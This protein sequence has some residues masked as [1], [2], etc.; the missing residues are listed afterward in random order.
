MD[1][2]N[3]HRSWPDLSATA[4]RGGCPYCLLEFALG[5]ADD[6]LRAVSEVEDSPKHLG[7]YTILETLGKGGMGVVY[8]AQH[9]G[10]GRV[11]ALKVLN[12][13]CAGRAEFPLRFQR[14]GQLLAALDHPNIVGVYDLGCEAGVFYL[15]MELVPG[16]TL[17]QCL[18]NG[19]LP[20][21]RAVA[22]FGQLCDA[23]QYA[24]ERGIIH[25]DVKPENILVDDK[26]HVKIGDFGIA[27]LTSSDSAVP[28]ALTASDAVIGTRCY[29]APEQ[30][31]R[32]KT[33]DH[34]ADLYAL[35]AVFYEMLTGELPLGVFAPPSR[36]AAV[37]PRLDAVLLK[38]LDKAPE[39]RYRSA[40]EFKEHVLQ[41]GMPAAPRSRRLP[42]WLRGAALLLALAFGV[43]AW[44]LLPPPGTGKEDARQ[45][46]VPASTPAQKEKLGVR[47]LS[48][49]KGRVWRVAFADDGRTLATASEDRTVKLWDAVHGRETA[50]WEAFPRGEFGYLSL[51]FSPDGKMLATAGGENVVRLWNVADR[52]PGQVL[53][54]HG[55]E[56]TGLAF[57]PDGTLLASASHDRSIR[58]WDVN[59]G[60][61]KRILDGFPDPVLSLAFSPDGKLLTAGAMSGAVKLYNPE[62]GEAVANCGHAKR[63]WSL[64]FSA[65]GRRLAT[66]SHESTIKIWDMT[67]RP[68]HCIVA[69]GGSEVWSV[70]FAPDA[71]LLASGSH[72]GS[73][74]LWDA[75]TGKIRAKWT[76]HS[77][78]VVSVAFS[79]KG[80]WLASG[81]WDHTA[82]LWDR[83]RP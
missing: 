34:R 60:K 29:M 72:D 16:H 27:K 47:V 55:R 83:K 69:P 53:T 39:S 31:E 73:V 80:R 68:L 67:R 57:S 44:W 28:S 66:G 50:S 59:T 71:D 18:A 52:K 11:V 1:C 46:L 15:A 9:G 32:G 38:A 17:R 3:C 25:R 41:A 77:A 19:P 24:H 64:A 7:P 37:D 13:A 12:P 74:R 43:L 79:P 70:A 10:L 40:A 45:S 2:P 63:V 5:E 21:P 82:I 8:R 58:L 22:M 61:A 81:S 4:L 33:V 42:G 75:N 14:E 78:P 56:V 30:L 36:I 49:H 76:G 20:W 26:G 54:G 48:G 6:E 35:A 51:A 23:L 65:D 62:T